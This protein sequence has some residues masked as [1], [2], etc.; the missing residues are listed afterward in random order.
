MKFAEVG[1]AASEGSLQVYVPYDLGR[2][3]DI[4][5]HITFLLGLIECM[6]W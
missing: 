6:G 1:S 2:G 4:S 3:V 5:V